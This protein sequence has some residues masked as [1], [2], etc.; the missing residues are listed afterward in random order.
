MKVL[1]TSIRVAELLTLGSKLVTYYNS[2]ESLADDE[3]LSAIIPTIDNLSQS[4]TTAYN[5]DRIKSDLDNADAT[6]DDAVRTLG[7]LIEAYASIP[8][9]ATQTAAQALK[10]V[11]D[12][13]GKKIVNESYAVES[14]N[15][16]SL[17]EDL[18]A[19]T[20]AS[21]IAAITGMSEAIEALR[22]AQAAFEEAD[23][24][25]SKAVSLRASSATSYRRS[26]MSA[27]NDQLVAFLNM[28]VIV[29]PDKY[30]TYAERVETAINIANT[31]V[32]KRSKSSSETTTETTTE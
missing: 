22:T 2:E 19:E 15:I 23:D 8:L 32:T 12:K 5:Q 17:L 4:M 28:A 29:F 21:S 16:N 26:L 6:R 31:T 3:F 27:I 11:F 1:S 18:A 13:Y 14:A 20:L 9:E 10:T 30:T 25:L 7:T 24:A